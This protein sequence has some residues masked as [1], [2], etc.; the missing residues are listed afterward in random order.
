M[1]HADA[2]LQEALGRIEK[3]KVE[4]NKS[5]TYGVIVETKDKSGDVIDVT[6]IE[7]VVADSPK[8]AEMKV[9]VKLAQAGKIIEGMEA[10][11]FELPFVK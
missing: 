1:Q 10:L 7:T 4:M 2:W 11:A 6:P 9:V 8:A 5:R 3:R